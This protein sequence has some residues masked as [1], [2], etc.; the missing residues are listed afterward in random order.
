M[1]WARSPRARARKAKAAAL[2]KIQPDAQICRWAEARPPRP[3]DGQGAA[4][5]E[6]S[7]DPRRIAGLHQARITVRELPSAAGPTT[8][9]FTFS[10]ALG[11]VHKVEISWGF[12][13]DGQDRLARAHGR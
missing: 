2:V 5:P 3:F 1:G 7:R 13:W 8:L 12:Q 6:R 4:C 9:A 11:P 10:A